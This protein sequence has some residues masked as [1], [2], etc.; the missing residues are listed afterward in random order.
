MF[1]LV[2]IV[3]FGP[4]KG[5]IISYKSSWSSVLYQQSFITYT[6]VMYWCPRWHRSEN[7]NIHKEKYWKQVEDEERRIPPYPFFDSTYSFWGRRG[8]GYLNDFEFGQRL[9]V[10]MYAKLVFQKRYCRR[11]FRA[12]LKRLKFTNTAH[13]QYTAITSRTTSYLLFFFWIFFFFFGETL[14]LLMFNYSTLMDSI[15]SHSFFMIKQHI[16]FM[17]NSLSSSLTN[18]INFYIY[19]LTSFAFLYLLNLNFIFNYNFFRNLLLV[20]VLPFIILFFW[21]V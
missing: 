4:K 18:S 12:Q 19:F 11:S 2:F 20:N 21:I 3:M 14:L 5:S 1:I 6:H 17:T 15:T 13:V 16:I 7:F 9:Y 8:A 10:Y